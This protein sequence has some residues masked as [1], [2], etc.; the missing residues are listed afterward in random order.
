MF[1]GIANIYSLT[2]FFGNLFIQLPTHT[3]VYPQDFYRKFTIKIFSFSNLATE[4]LSCQFCW[5]IECRI[6]F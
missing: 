6:M 5:K 4:Q 1:I 3:I 2:Q